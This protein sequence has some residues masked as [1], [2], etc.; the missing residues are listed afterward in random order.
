MNRATSEHLRSCSACSSSTAATGKLAA[1]PEVN[2]ST[3]SVFATDTTYFVDHRCTSCD[4]RWLYYT[5]GALGLDSVSKDSA[6]PGLAREDAYARLVAV[7]PLPEQR[8]IA[9]F[10]DRDGAMVDAAVS[11]VGLAVRYLQEYRA[12]LVTAAVTGCIDV[13][14]SFAAGT[15]GVLDY[16]S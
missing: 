12:A 14:G 10:L 15:G 9:D 3:S 8:A 5:L 7:P 4:L 13:R 1:T 11:K 6:V 16:A 2:Y